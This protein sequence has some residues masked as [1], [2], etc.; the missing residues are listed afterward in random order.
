V[1][2]ISGYGDLTAIAAGAQRFP[3]RAVSRGRESVVE[4]VRDPQS[5][6][7]FPVGLKQIIT[8]PSGR[9]W[10]GGGGS[11]LYIVTLEGAKQPV[12]EE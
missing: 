5:L 9:T 3:L 11:H 2:S 4:G 1:E 10:V 12:M 8:Q 7:W 6:A